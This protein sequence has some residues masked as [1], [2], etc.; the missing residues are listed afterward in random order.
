MLDK[1]LTAKRSCQFVVVVF[2]GDVTPFQN[3]VE[4]LFKALIPTMV[5]FN[6][7]K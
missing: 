5:D 1:P 2:V 7:L 4:S 3:A 6:S